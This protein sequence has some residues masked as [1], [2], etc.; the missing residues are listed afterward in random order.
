[1]ACSTRDELNA[2]DT[3]GAVPQ[4]IWVSALVFAVLS[5][6]AGNFSQGF[7]EADACTHFLSAKFGFREPVRLVSVWDRPLFMAL[8]TPAA[9]LAGTTG[10]RALSLV[11]ALLCGWCS[12]RIAR[13]LGLARP[14]LAMVFTLGQPLLFLHSFSEMTELSFAALIGLAFLAYLNE[15][16]VWMAVLV[17]ISPLGRPEGFGFLLLAAAVLALRRQWIVISLLPLGVLL[18][19]LVGWVLWERPDYGLGWLNFLTWLPRHWPYSGTSVYESG[20]LVFWKRQADGTLG[21]SFLVRLPMLIGPLLFPFLMVGTGLLLRGF[22][23]KMRT[24]AGRGVLAAVL[25]PWAILAGH[26]LLWWRGWMASSG[27]LRYLLIVA[28]LWA[29]VGS[30]GF[31]FVLG[32][33]L[34]GRKWLTQSTLAGALA[35]LPALANAHLRV[36]PLP[37]YTDDRLARQV[38]DW[39]SGDGEL[40]SK[41]PRLTAGCIAVYHRLDFSPTDW[42]RTVLW[43]KKMVADRPEGVVLIWDDYNGSHNADANMCITWQELMDN[44]W[45]EIKQFHEAGRTWHAMVPGSDAGGERQSR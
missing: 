30:A 42:T 29:V 26:S 35:L 23:L 37:L 33:R 12:W 4:V 19:T 8:Y 43:N 27:E 17:A 22:A 31:T 18:W 6:V 38:S 3:S 36:V 28:P 7:L 25:L 14:E 32:D 45:V 21:G 39:Y 1:M 5:L 24:A 40:H 20:P 15:R 44:R 2:S 10:A 16:W 9:V 13:R 34:S 11:L 41:Y